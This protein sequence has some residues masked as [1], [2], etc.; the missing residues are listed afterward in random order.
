MSATNAP[1]NLDCIVIFIGCPKKNPAISERKAIVVVT[2]KG[3]GD[4]TTEA[5]TGCPKNSPTI[6]ERKAIVVVA[7]KGVGNTMM[8][9]S[10]GSLVKLRHCYQGPG[11][12]RAF[13]PTVAKGPTHTMC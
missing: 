13:R 7:V 6:P 9:A 8:E 1:L 5:S 3:V 10:T 4:T 11:Q 2:G 12:S